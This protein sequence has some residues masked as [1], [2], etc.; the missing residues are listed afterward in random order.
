MLVVN[1][2]KAR[3]KTPDAKETNEANTIRELLITCSEYCDAKVNFLVRMQYA[4]PIKI[5][6]TPAVQTKCTHSVYANA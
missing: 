6:I 5:M 1:F 2:K 4:S 3:R